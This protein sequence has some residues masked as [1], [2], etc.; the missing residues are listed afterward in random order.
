[1]ENVLDSSHVSFTH[2]KSMSDRNSIGRYSD[3]HI[4]D[5]V[6]HSGFK[7]EWPTGP[8]G[9]RLGPQK[10]EWRPPGFLKHHL[11]TKSSDSLV[12][13]YAV[14]SSPGRCRL[15]NRNVVRLKAK[16]FLLPLIKGL[17]RSLTSGW[18]S[19]VSSHTLLEDDQIFLHIAETEIAKR[20][21]ANKLMGKVQ[22]N[23]SPA[24]SIV[25]SFHS[26]LSK[27]GGPFGDIGRKTYLESLGPRLTRE[28]LLDRYSQHTANCKTCLKALKN[29]E[30]LSLF[31]KI[32]SAV[33]LVFS[34][35]CLFTSLGLSAGITS[36]TSQLL[37]DGG[38]LSTNIQF[39]ALLILGSTLT[40]SALTLRGLGWGLG[41]LILVGLKGLSDQTMDSFKTGQYPPPRNLAKDK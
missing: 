17:V 34:L 19:H 1:M 13:V 24:D 32:S 23:P 10:T 41:A 30:Q 35:S 5:K 37:L 20:K 36:T 39:L 27:F 3:I 16:S 8:R 33:L 25:V 11:I 4:T 31:L 18:R 40:A 29:L 12:I 14:P 38:A 9:G 28:E 2:H 21:I 7:A 15:I 22:Y 26:F 6:S